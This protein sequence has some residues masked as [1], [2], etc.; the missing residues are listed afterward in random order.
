MNAETLF[1][2]LSCPSDHYT[3]GVRARERLEMDMIKH[4]AEHQTRSMTRIL[5]FAY[6]INA[7]FRAIKQRKLKSGIYIFGMTPRVTDQMSGVSSATPYTP[8]ASP[9]LIGSRNGRP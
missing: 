2:A 7:S 6:K 5:E 8:L 3:C 4:D 1:P 9:L